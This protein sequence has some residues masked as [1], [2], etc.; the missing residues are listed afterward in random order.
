MSKDLRI[1]VLGRIQR[2][3]GLKGEIRVTAFGELLDRFTPDS[4]LSLYSGTGTLDGFITDPVFEKSAILEKIIE[5]KG[6]GVYILRFQD[7]N[8]LEQIDNELKGLYIGMPE[9]EAKEKYFDREN[10][11]LFQWLGMDVYDSSDPEIK[12]G[13]IINISIMAG[14]A[15]LEIDSGTFVFLAPG[16]FLES[17]EVDWDKKSVWMENA[18]EWKNA[19]ENDQEGE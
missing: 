2:A 17:A 7:I 3:K 14:R 9:D 12:I 10:P 5:N 6:N 13:T 4:P 15:V 8:T 18:A 19:Q 16:D 1:L 11:Y